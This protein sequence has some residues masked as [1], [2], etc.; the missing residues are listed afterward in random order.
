[1]GITARPTTYRGIHMRSRL[2]ARVAA[3]LDASGHEWVYEPNAFASPGGQYLPDFRVG[4][5]LYIEVKPLLTPLE[6]IRVQRQMTIIW[7]SEPNAEL[8]IWLNEQGEA[9]VARGWAKADGWQHR[10]GLGWAA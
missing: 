5:D 8:M 10:V 3:V 1:M 7:D 2:E 6:L 9:W 4:T